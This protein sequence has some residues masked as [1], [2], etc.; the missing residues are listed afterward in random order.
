MAQALHLAN[1]A[2]INEKLRSNEGAVA[3]AAASKATDAEVLD[4]LFLAAL[5]RRPTPGE[6]ERVLKVLADA[7]AGL[8]D[9]KAVAEAR[10]QAIEDLYW[11]TLTGHEFLFN[12]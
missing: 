10:R 6:R 4:R 8:G 3:R 2:T 1:G 5:S 12:H 9:P 11:A 7:V